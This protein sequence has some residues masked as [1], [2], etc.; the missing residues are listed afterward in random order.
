MTLLI[1]A[2]TRLL[3]QGLGRDGGFQASRCRAYGTAMVAGVHPG[4]GETFFEDEV[5]VFE[6]AARAEDATGAN[7]GLIFVPAPF[8]ADAIIEQADAGLSLIVAI[9]E[10]IPVMD[11]VHVMAYLQENSARLLGPNC[12][13][14]IIPSAQVKVGIIPGNILKPG[15]VGVVSRSGTLTYEAVIQLTELGI[16]Q[17]TCVGIGGDPVHGTTFVDVLKEFEDDPGTEAIVMIGEIGG[18]QE[19]Q[20][21]E[22]IA[23]SVTKPVVALIVGQTAP[24]GKRMGHAGAIVTGKSALAEEKV[25]VL[26][27]SGALV[28]DSPAGIGQ[29]VREVL[30]P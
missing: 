20:A 11:M 4:R 24:P 15:R 9:T 6:S 7:V 30:S 27:E 12:P 8:A 19:Q 23:K 18:T 13:G 25:R 14:F 2:E 3:V 22:F 5:P 28:V 29:G 16:G 17:S 26:R 21:A 10:G 1:P